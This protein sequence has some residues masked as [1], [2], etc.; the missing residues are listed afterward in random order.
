MKVHVEIRSTKGVR[1]HDLTFDSTSVT[2]YDVLASM[3]Q[4]EWGQDL[5]VVNEGDDRLKQVPGYL[6]VLEKRMVQNWEVE[7]ISV[8]DGH[9]LKFVKAVPGG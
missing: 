2:L 1:R 9:H 6:M 4:H 3:S 5:F 8:L 7:D